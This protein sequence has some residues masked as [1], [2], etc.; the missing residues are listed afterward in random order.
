MN[1]HDLGLK[2]KTD[3]AHYHNFTQIYDDALKHL[4]GKNIN[5]LEIGVEHGF[6]L[7]MWNEFFQN[8]NIFGADIDDK[9]FLNDKNIKTF[10]VDQ[11]NYFELI[12]LPGDLDVIVDDGGHTMLQQQI[13]FKT[14]F[15]KKLKNGGYFILEDLHTSKKP[16]YRTHGSNDKN[17]TLNLLY[18]L[19]NG[20]LSK[21]HEYYI[22]DFEFNNLLKLID[23]IKVYE[24][25]EDSITS[26][27]TKK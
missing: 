23:D 10:K 1:L 22:N 20:S 13:T 14:L 9:S 5:F 12:S 21:N 27:I 24:V 15:D 26:I 4:I 25:G 17:N 16:Y 19:K 7:K 18:D 6:S 8:A 2:Y 11:E 3:K